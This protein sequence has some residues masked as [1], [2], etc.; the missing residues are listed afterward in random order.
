MLLGAY[1]NEIALVAFLLL[2]VLLA[3]KV[4]RVGEAIGGLFERK[5]ATADGAAPEAPEER[6]EG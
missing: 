5:P 6:R 4:G 1:P 2:V 3:T